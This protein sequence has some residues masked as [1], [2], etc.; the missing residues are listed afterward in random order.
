MF[1]T[2]IF[3]GSLFCGSAVHI[4]KD[5]IADSHMQGA[6][7]R[8]LILRFCSPSGDSSKPGPPPHGGIFEGLGFFT[9]RPKQKGGDGAKTHV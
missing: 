2:S 8:D 4:L 6:D 7:R 9:S 5:L 1:F 3:C